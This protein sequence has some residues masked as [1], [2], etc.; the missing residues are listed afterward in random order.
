MQAPSWRVLLTG[1]GQL[2]KK[3]RGGL[4]GRRALYLLLATLAIAGSV[5]WFLAAAQAATGLSVS[6]LDTEDPV[7]EVGIGD[8][9]A[10]SPDAR[11]VFTT[12]ET[13]HQTYLTAYPLDGSGLLLLQPIL[14]PGSVAGLV[15]GDV[16]VSGAIVHLDVPS[17]TPLYTPYV[18]DDPRIPFGRKQVVD[19]QRQ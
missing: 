9:P 12:L 7:R 6:L 8:R 11:Y 15:W 1:S 10:F 14:M 17:P 18:V 13:P 5:L 4:L 2:G 16:N 3:P 19:H